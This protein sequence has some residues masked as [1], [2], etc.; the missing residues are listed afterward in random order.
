MAD[1]RDANEGEI[2][3]LLR[4]MG[5]IVIQMDR[6][7]GFDLVV[8]TPADGKVHI[9][10]VKNPERKWKLTPAEKTKKEQVEAAGGKYEIV[11]TLADAQRLNNLEA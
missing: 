1:K 10:E 6:H 4:Y 7:A 3:E 11:E 5:C 8:V 9:V 2:I